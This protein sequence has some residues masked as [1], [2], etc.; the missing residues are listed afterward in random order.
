MKVC[1]GVRG[2][3]PPP[4]ESLRASGFDVEGHGPAFDVAEHVT[5]ERDV[6]HVYADDGSEVNLLRRPHVVDAHPVL[7]TEAGQDV[8]KLWKIGGFAP[9]P[10]DFD[11]TLAA[12][13]KAFPAAD[14]KQ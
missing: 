3:V 12:S 14:A 13:L 9:V 10:A 8:M 1:A 2:R 7:V 4:C 6:S 11:E 5:D